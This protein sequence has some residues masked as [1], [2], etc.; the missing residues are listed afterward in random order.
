MRVML[1]VRLAAYGQRSLALPAPM[2]VA[3]RWF[4]DSKRLQ[5]VR[6]AHQGPLLLE[7]KTF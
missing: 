4:G 7:E 6:D 5:H 3:D 1:D 2:R